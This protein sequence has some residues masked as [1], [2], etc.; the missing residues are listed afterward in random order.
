MTDAVGPEW[1][2]VRPRAYR[3]MRLPDAL[4]AHQQYFVHPTRIF[5]GPDGTYWMVDLDD[6]ARLSAFGHRPLSE[7][8]AQFSLQRQAASERVYGVVGVLLFVIG[9]VL[10]IWA[11]QLR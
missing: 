1:M 6:A 10:L 4:R 11:G 7:S 8:Q 2:I 9:I 3:F 5:R